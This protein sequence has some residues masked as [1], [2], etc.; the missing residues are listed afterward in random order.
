MQNHS[1]IVYDRG[2][3]E[4]LNDIPEVADLQAARGRATDLIATLNAS[5]L[6]GT[7]GREPH[8]QAAVTALVA[9][10][11][12][13]ATFDFDVWQAEQAHAIARAA[14][15]AAD[16]VQSLIDDRLLVAI[17]A[18][19]TPVLDRLDEQLRDL[20]DHARA[21]DV[22]GARNAEDAIARGSAN[23][24][25]ERA[26]A[27]AVY[28]KI[29][30]TQRYVM[31]EYAPNVDAMPDTHAFIANLNDVWPDWHAYAG[32]R[33]SSW[34]DP[35]TGDTHH[36]P[37]PPWP[38]DDDGR[39]VWLLEHPEAQAWVPSPTRLAAALERAVEQLDEM[40][41]PTRHA[42][43][44]AA[45]RIRALNDSKFAFG[46]TR[47]PIDDAAVAHLRRA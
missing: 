10:E 28:S 4:I 14:V 21:L 12:V 39:F 30:T 17:R 11:P 9:D 27:R 43:Q 6:N 35:V 40:G 42:Q 5:T 34:I 16:R 15:Q 47:H 7:D 22:R 24:W 37:M 29:R 41:H 19:A 23:A 38:T 45:A 1:A 13:S 3:G 36:S 33:G 20:I 46:V 32:P 31:K 26:K 18:A 44:R 8:I 25:G 2:L